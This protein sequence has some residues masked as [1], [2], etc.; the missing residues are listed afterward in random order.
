MAGEEICSA[1]IENNLELPQNIKNRS[2]ILSCNSSSDD[3][4]KG[5]EHR[6]SKRYIYSHAY[7][8]NICIRQDEETTSVHMSRWMSNKNMVCICIQPWEI[9]TF[10]QLQLPIDEP[11]GH[12]AKWDAR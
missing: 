12:S 6:I 5:D 8:S 10:Y 7:C 2:T 3:I 9:K 1:T 11:S 4:H